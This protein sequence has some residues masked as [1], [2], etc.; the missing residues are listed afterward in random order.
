MSLI[1]FFGTYCRHYLTV[2]CLLPVVFTIAKVYTK[3]NLTFSLKRR[4]FLPKIVCFR[5]SLLLESNIEQTEH[6]KIIFCFFLERRPFLPQL[7]CFWSSLLL[8]S[9][10]EQTEHTK[11]KIIFSLE[12][13][14]F[15]PQLVCYW[16]SLLS[17]D[18]L[19]TVVKNSS[20]PIDR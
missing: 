5:S 7:V 14:Q 18:F 10:I 13:R 8:E 1:L 11:N 12:R 9:N 2:I 3:I 6:T 15:L 19:P 16:S 4:Q 17:A 20:F